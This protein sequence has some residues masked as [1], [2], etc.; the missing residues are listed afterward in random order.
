MNL[1]EHDFLSTFVPLGFL[2]N[3]SSLAQNTIQRDL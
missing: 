2:Q 1:I 3:S